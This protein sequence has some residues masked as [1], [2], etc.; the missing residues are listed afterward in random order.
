MIDSAELPLVVRFRDYPGPVGVTLEP[1]L[2]TRPTRP[3]G[4]SLGTF[5]D[6]R[7][8]EIPQ[9]CNATM[10]NL[11]ADAGLPSLLPCHYF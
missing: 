6:K 3:L 7:P 4:A 11:R 8:T 1:V 10:E 9:A 5:N 2:S